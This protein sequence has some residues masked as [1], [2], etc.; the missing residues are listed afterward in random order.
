V[1]GQFVVLHGLGLAVPLSVVINLVGGLYFL[2][3]LV[4]A[5]RL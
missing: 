2:I 5:V 1:L 3:L 4:K